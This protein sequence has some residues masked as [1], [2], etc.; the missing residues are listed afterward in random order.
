MC[1]NGSST[2][3]RICSIW[4]GE[5]ADVAVVDVGDLLE[6]ELLDLALGDPLVRVAAAGVEQQRVAGLERRVEQRVG[7]HD[8]PLL[9]GVVED[10]GAAGGLALL[11]GEQL[12]EHDDVALLDERERAHDVH[13]LVE[14]DLLAALQGVGVDLGRER[15]AHLAPAGEDVDGAVLVGAQVGAVAA[16]RLG[17]ALD[18]LLEREDLVAGLAQGADQPVVLPEGAGE[19][20]LR[21]GEA[22][23]ERAH[24]PRA[25]GQLAPQHGDL[26]L[27]EAHLGHQLAG[28]TVLAA[29]AVASCHVP[30]LQVRPHPTYGRSGPAARAPRVRPARRGRAVLEV[31]G[32]GQRR[33]GRRVLA[34]A[35]AARAADGRAAALRRAVRSR[36]GRRAAD[37]CRPATSAYTARSTTV[38]VRCQRSRVRSM[39]GLAG[40]G[41]GAGD[42]GVVDGGRVPWGLHPRARRARRAGPGRNHP[43]GPRRT[44]IATAS[45]A[46]RAGP[47]GSPVVAR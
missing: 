23:L 6:D 25:V 15:H 10:E 37:H 38:A 42:R 45:R 34:P 13:R 41:A 8:H 4:P 30:H 7:Q 19:R 1:R 5:P 31:G 20:G 3:S 18:L 9:V 47:S 11:R 44:R 36:P 12:L 39:R 17:E 40:T 43:D 46:G 24:L 32:A 26:L 27:E 2:A 35:D 22:L 29:P 21:L 28:P 33:A 16:R 14:H